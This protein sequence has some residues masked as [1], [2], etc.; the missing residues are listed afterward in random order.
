MSARALARPLAALAV[1]AALGLAGSAEAHGRAPQPGWRGEFAYQ[2]AAGSPALAEAAR[3][4]GA[5]KFTP[6]P[7]PWCADAVSFWLRAAGHR[8][9]AN[10][11][12]ASALSYGP[13]L[14][15]PAVGALVV[16]RTNRGIAGHVGL[17]EGVNP[18]GSIRIISGN[19]GHRVARSI[20]PRRM[21]VAIVE[22]R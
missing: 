8:P 13:H 21:V 11:L 17:V 7:G 19:W 16:I 6:F 1:F 12:A 22:V 15:S 3:W 9:L 20:V 4:V 18:D 5:G 14:R 10:R 2:P